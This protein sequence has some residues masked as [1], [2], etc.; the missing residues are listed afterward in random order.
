MLFYGRLPVVAGGGK[1]GGGG[2]GG[3]GGGPMKGREKEKKG[4]RGSGGGGILGS[5]DFLYLTAAAQR[6]AGTTGNG[7]KSRQKR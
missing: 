1:I 5:H 2:G 6:T 7:E 4:E 3:G